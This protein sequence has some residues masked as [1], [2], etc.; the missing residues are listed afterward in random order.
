MNE[1]NK[2]EEV[3][4]TIGYDIPLSKDTFAKDKASLFISFSIGGDKLDK[5][6]YRKEV[7]EVVKELAEDTKQVL[8]EQWVGI[9]ETVEELKSTRNDL[10]DKLR[11]ELSVE[12]DGKLAK[13]K[14]MILELREENKLLKE[15][16]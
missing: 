11:A 10:I 6:E 13:A 12:Y 1:L 14:E 4:A 9:S 3:K 5:E 8:R 2:Y 16:K 7:R 15:N